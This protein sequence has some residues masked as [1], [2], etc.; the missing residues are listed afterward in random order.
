VNGAIDVANTARTRINLLKRSAQEAPAQNQ[1]LVAEAKALET[2]VN[3]IINSLRGGR[4]NSDSPPPSISNR[5]E[6]VADTIRLSSVRPTQ[7]QLNQYNF[8]STQFNP[9]LARLR[10]LVETEIPNLE[11]ALNAVGAPLTPGRLPQ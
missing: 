10:T 11:R 8:A 4:E 2:K 7:T 1:N 3:D 9:V 6:L 5:V